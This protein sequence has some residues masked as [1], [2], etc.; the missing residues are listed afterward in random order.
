MRKL[1]QQNDVNAFES[2]ISLSRRW[3]KIEALKQIFFGKFQR[4]ES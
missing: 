3:E 1:L 4:S 2:L